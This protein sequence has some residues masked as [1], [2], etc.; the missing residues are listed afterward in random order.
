MV[1]KGF[2]SK[3]VHS[4]D[5]TID[6]VGNVVTPVFENST[7][8]FNDN[9]VSGDYIYSRWGNPTVESF[10]RKYADLENTEHALAFSS[11]MSAITSSVMAMIKSGDSLL[12]INELYGQTFEFFSN[13]LPKYNINVDFTTVEDLNSGNLKNKNYKLLY[14]ESITNPLLEVPDLINLSKI[15][16]EMGIR[17]ATDATFAT[18]Y[19]QNPVSMGAD[20]VLHSGTKYISGHSDLLI[21]LAGFNRYYDEFAF[22]RKTFGGTPDAFQA[23]LAYRGLKTLGIRME[24]HIKMPW[25]LR[26]FLMTLKKLKRCI[27]LD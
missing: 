19:N 24:R 9:G 18:P 14:I 2:N 11:G 17:I 6:G 12:T 16:H 13:V 4:G 21:G 3:C 22:S 7:F 8:E 20:L 15:C 1:N 26:R 10:E 23:Y 25:S 27:I 5:M